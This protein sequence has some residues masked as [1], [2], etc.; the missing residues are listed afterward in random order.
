MLDVSGS[1]KEKSGK[2]YLTEKISA[3]KNV[4]FKINKEDSAWYY[5]GH[6]SS[7]QKTVHITCI[8]S[9]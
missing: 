1:I 2:F 3:G 8:A 6:V 5:E 7:D 4:K 9:L